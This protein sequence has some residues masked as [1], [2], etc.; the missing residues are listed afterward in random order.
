MLLSHAEASSFALR[1]RLWLT[2]SNT[3]GH[4]PNTHQQIYAAF[5]VLLR[6]VTGSA[7]RNTALWHTINVD[8]ER[9]GQAAL[10]FQQQASLL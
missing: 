7:L 5:S 10:A 8:L 6:T 3:P 2:P 1:A 4:P 9:H